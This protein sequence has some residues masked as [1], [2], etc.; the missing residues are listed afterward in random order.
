[1]KLR[2]SEGR[3]G[4]TISSR[5]LAW[6]GLKRRFIAALSGPRRFGEVTFTMAAALV[7]VFATGCNTTPPMPPTDAQDACPLSAATFNTWF[8]S[9]SVTLNGVVNPANSLNIPAPNCG[10]YSWSEQ[11]FLWLTSPAPPSY[12]GGANIFDSPTFFDVSPPDASGH[13]TFLPHVPGAIRPFPLPLRV[14]QRG[15][16]GL[17]VIL[18]RNKQLFEIAPPAASAKAMVRDQSGKIVEIAHA[19][20]TDGRLTLLDAQ[21]NIIAHQVAKPVKAGEPKPAVEPK[22]APGKKSKPGAQNREV[23]NP[24]LAT[25]FII[26]RI[27]IFLDPSLA[28]IDVEQGQA[29]DNSVLQAQTT[30]NGSLVYYATMVNDVYAYFLTGA[31]DGAITTTPANQFPTSMTDL[32]NTINFAIAHGRPILPSRTP[33][34]WPSRSRPRG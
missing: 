27:P 12:G 30:V 29:E 24:L 22:P 9:G 3:A 19:K 23:T 1:M 17:P 15:A 5:D 13:R 34:L 26:D 20:L 28:V 21:G 31:K 2:V 10:F 4:K 18:D 32:N 33:T 7:L 6:S 25:R 14:A 8:Q 16:H 11:M